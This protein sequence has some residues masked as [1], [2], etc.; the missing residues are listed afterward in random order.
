MSNTTCGAQSGVKGPMREGDVTMARGPGRSLGNDSQIPFRAYKAI[1]HSAETPPPK[2]E[3]R[4]PMTNIQ[5]S[6]SKGRVLAAIGG[7]ASAPQ[8]RIT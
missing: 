7:A 3:I 8:E 6:S 5:T 1:S 2:F 4:N